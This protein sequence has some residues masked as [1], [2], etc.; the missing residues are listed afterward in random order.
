MAV[1]FNPPPGWPPAPSGWQPPPGWRPDPSWPAPPPGWQLWVET[2]R[3]EDSHVEVTHQTQSAQPAQPVQPYQV[4]PIHQV[5]NPYPNSEPATQ[6]HG[7]MANNSSVATPAT[8]RFAPNSHASASQSQQPQAQLPQAAGSVTDEIAGGGFQRRSQLRKTKKKSGWLF[9]IIISSVAVVT[10][11][12]V[13]LWKGVLSSGDDPQP[14]ATNS[15]PGTNPTTVE[16]SETDPSSE[17]DSEPTTSLNPDN[18]ALT[19]GSLENP[20]PINTPVVLLDWEVSLGATDTDAWAQVSSSLSAEDQEYYAPEDGVS[21]VSVPITV[22]YKGAERGAL[23]D[24]TIEY[25]GSDAQPNNESCGWG[26]IPDELDTS[27]ELDPDQTVTGNV[28]VVVPTQTA[29]DGA[30]KINAF[31]WDFNSS[32]Q[33]VFIGTR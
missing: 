6:A 2:A 30:W 32:D 10:V 11:L 22:T 3:V 13:V 24:L 7:S 23:Y 16:P 5:S 17:P 20:E 29:N 14:Q 12:A 15:T 18:N 4:A 25:V 31:N 33:E 9:P 1:R 21:F 27:V 26:I 28:C 8:E 19:Q